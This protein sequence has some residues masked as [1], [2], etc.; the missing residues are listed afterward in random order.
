MKKIPLSEGKRQ[1][2]GKYQALVD[3]CDYEYL[4]QWKWYARKIK[5]TIYAVREIRNSDGSRSLIHMHRE[6]LHLS[7]DDPCVVD[8]IN[9]NGID[10]RSDNIRAVTN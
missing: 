10:N 4:M 2:R 5:K 7:W 6:I 1:N 9:H 8:H 3:D